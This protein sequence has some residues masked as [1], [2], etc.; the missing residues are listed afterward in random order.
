M[1]EPNQTNH[2][3]Q[4][5]TFVLEPRG[6]FLFI[7]V[8]IILPCVVLLVVD[9][10]VVNSLTKVVGV[11]SV[12]VIAVVISVIDD[13][14]VAVEVTVLISLL[15][16]LVVVDSALVGDTLV[17]PAILCIVTVVVVGEVVCTFVLVSSDVVDGPVVAGIVDFEATLVL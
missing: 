10:R 5:P 4:V 12:N 15:E 9:S 1:L 6:C 8:L 7:F 16:V 14:S 17:V 2:I 3:L 11:V 13:I